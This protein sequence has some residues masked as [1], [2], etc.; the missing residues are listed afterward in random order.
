MCGGIDGGKSKRERE[1]EMEDR[2]KLE[3]DKVE[4]VRH[5]LSIPIQ[6]F[7]WLLSSAAFMLHS[8]FRGDK[9]YASQGKRVNRAV[10]SLADAEEGPTLHADLPQTSFTSVGGEGFIKGLFRLLTF[11]LSGSLP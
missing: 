4:Q 5:S 7:T 2:E 6:T 11:D 3:A 10:Q 1:R 8:Q 9:L